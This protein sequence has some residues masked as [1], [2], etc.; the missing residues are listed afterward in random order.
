M[1][2]AVVGATG[3]IGTKVVRQLNEMG[4]QTRSLA[5]ELGVD[6]LTGEGL[7][8]GL[9]GADVLLDVT[10]AP[11]LD[12]EA[13]TKFFSTASTNL[14]TAAKAARVSHYVALS[15]VGVQRLTESAYM[16][17]KVIQERTVAD[18]GLPYTIM[19]STQFHEFTSAIA[20]NYL[21]SREF[22]VPDALIQ[23]IAADEVVAL[24]AR[25]T[26]D[27]P[28]NGVIHVGGPDKVSFAE[29]TEMLVRFHGVDFA[30]VVDPGAKY[31]GS[32][33]QT[34]SL[35]ADDDAVIGTMRLPTWLRPSPE[36]IQVAPTG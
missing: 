36:R 12:T 34:S 5:L 1:K 18:S 8:E 26:V 22:R 3:L 11:V 27:E 32:R 17:G 15:I 29:M 33:L 4:H 31:F 20:S 19:R 28:V 6:V 25:A 2:V 30:T 13:A 16:R 21:G 35:I 24:L 9:A 14:V 23:P 10:N 7:D